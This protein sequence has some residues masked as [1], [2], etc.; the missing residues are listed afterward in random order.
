MHTEYFKLLKLKQ[1]SWESRHTPLKIGAYSCCRVYNTCHDITKMC[2]LHLWKL[3]AAQSECDNIWRH[4]S[5]YSL[6]VVYLYL[7][8]VAENTLEIK[9]TNWEHCLVTV[10][11]EHIG[12][13]KNFLKSWRKNIPNGWNIFW[14]VTF[15]CFLGGKSSEVGHRATNLLILR[16][17]FG[18]KLFWHLRI[19]NFLIS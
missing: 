17:N 16:E 4:I 11:W 19:R 2:E 1:N 13:I 12:R 5:T 10:C 9:L 7:R 3:M 8:S 6:W 14:V 18:A 15:S